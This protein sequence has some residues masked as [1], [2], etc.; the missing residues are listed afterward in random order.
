[1]KLNKRGKSKFLTISGE[2]NSSDGADITYTDFPGN[3]SNK[4]DWVELLT[5][6]E[7]HKLTTWFWSFM[8]KETSEN[9]QHNIEAEGQ[10]W[11]T[12]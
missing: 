6:K 11:M 10:I 7:E 1:M 12:E 2:Q 9:S 4:I 3:Q 5:W 8:E